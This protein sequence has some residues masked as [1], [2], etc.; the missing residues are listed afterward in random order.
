VFIGQSNINAL[1]NF[2]HLDEEDFIARFLRKV[3][4]RFAL[5]EIEVQ[6]GDF[7]CTFLDTENGHCT[8]YELRPTQCR[9]FPFWEHF[10]VNPDELGDECPGILKETQ[11]DS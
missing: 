9:T 1:A 11:S 5:R 2:L 10:L 4:A 3:G 6:K 8:V 7:A